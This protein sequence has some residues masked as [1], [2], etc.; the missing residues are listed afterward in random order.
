MKYTTNQCR[1]QVRQKNEFRNNND[2]IFG[3]WRADVYVVCSYG[4]HFPMFIW[5][6]N[7][8]FENS[9]KYSH[10]T[11]KQMGQVRPSYDTKHLTNNQ[12]CIVQREGYAALV[13]YRLKGE[14]I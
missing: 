10:T 7:Q 11:T 4:W 13:K 3:R 2:T 12:M 8:W 5:A 1:E 14:A 6:N 9:S